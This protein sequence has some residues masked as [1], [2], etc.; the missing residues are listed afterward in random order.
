MN[1]Q[2]GDVKLSDMLNLNEHYYLPNNDESYIINKVY[3]FDQ[4]HSVIAVNSENL[5]VFHQVID[6]LNELSIDRVFDIL[7]E[8]SKKYNKKKQEP[9]KFITN[10]SLFVRDSKF[11]EKMKLKVST[12]TYYFYEINSKGEPNVLYSYY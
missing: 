4:N 10:L 7:T 2:N 5:V 1:K 6:D 8:N 9:Y 11:I 12:S 3:G